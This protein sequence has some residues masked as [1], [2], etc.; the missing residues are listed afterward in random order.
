MGRD[1]INHLRFADDIF[2]IANNLNEIEI[3]L[4]D[5]DTASRNRGSKMKMKKTKVMA[6]LSVEHKPVIIN[7][8]QLEH[9][10]EYIYP[11]QLFNLIKRNQD[12]EIRR[13]I[14]TG[15]QTFD[16]YKG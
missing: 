7:G 8:I 3:I 13:M 11:G 2:I 4:Q 1:S 15:G 9:V 12:N 5:L 10:S 14:K 16:R 6:D